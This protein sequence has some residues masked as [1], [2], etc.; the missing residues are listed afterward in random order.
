MAG[1]INQEFEMK[2]N[3][4]RG[5]FMK[6]TVG[7]NRVRPGRT[8]DNDKLML[9]KSSMGILRQNIAQHIGDSR[10]DSFLFQFGW[11]MGVQDANDLLKVKKPL[12]QYVVDGPQQHIRNGHI[13]GIDHQC[14]IEYNEDGTL[15]TL[16][17]RGEWHGSY[18]AREH[19]ARFGQSKSPVCHT[20]TGYSSG[21]MS[22]IFNRVLIAKEITCVARGD[23]ACQWM[24]RPKE[25]WRGDVDHVPVGLM[26]STPIVKELEVTYDQL[27]EQTEFI[28]SL[29]EFQKEL[30]EEVVN[31]RDLNSIL[32]TAYKFTKM[33]LT[34]DNLVF[35]TI[36]SVGFS[37]GDIEKLKRDSEVDIPKFLIKD[38]GGYSFP[39][40]KYVHEAE[41]YH[42]VIAP[43]VVE[44]EILGYCSTITST[45]RD[46]NYHEEHLYLDHLSNTVALI[47]Q[48]EKAKIETLGRMKG[49]YLEQVIHKEGSKSELLRRGK[50]IGVDFDEPYLIFVLDAGKPFDSI[51]EEF[52]FQEKVQEETYTYF[53][54]LRKT[55]LTAIINDR[56]ITMVMSPEN[57]TAVIKDY[58]KRIKDKI[59]DN[60]L[61]IGISN[62]HK[63]I[64]NT[65]RIMEEAVI[66]S[67]LAVQN[68]TMFYRELGIVGALIN[69]N[70][71][72]SI[73][74]IADEELEGLQDGEGNL[75]K[76]LLKTLYYFLSN[77][78]N[79]K[80]TSTD[81]ALS[82]SGLRHRIQKIEGLIGKDLRDPNVSNHLLL[83]IK[84]VIVL[85]E[86]DLS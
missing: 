54:E 47:M 16:V 22:T 80:N 59:L 62:V 65:R 20:L 61:V 29:S 26:D 31:G 40:Q 51:E 48:N 8:G 77:G 46:S 37:D 82:M 2:I 1:A 56:I 41:H 39:F 7:E 70:N 68:K 67:R 27:L 10:L 35:E 64:E 57:M 9:S 32:T 11:D 28:T 52:S 73:E 43:I 79:L 5:G 12:E 42:R 36:A 83:I 85:K 25:D 3:F 19:L 86:V 21:L 15:K 45:R 33:P 4:F 14:D 72:K 17:G 50:Y 34:I 81:L 13:T 53:K 84:A 18:E 44:K 24:I 55:V 60:E 69:A 66:A 6:I 38:K 75:D 71:E 49:H 23:H 58:Q 78:G 63:G 74:Y 76:E 30:T